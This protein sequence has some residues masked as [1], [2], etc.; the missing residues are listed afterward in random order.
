MNESH[1]AELIGC[2][3]TP[4]YS[5][6]VFHTL[7]MPNDILSTNETCHTYK[8]V[9]SHA[10]THN[11]FSIQ[12]AEG[13]R[14]RPARDLAAMTHG[15]V[16]PRFCLLCHRL[17]SK[18]SSLRPQTAHE[19]EKQNRNHNTHVGVLLPAVRLSSVERF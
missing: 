17:L 5:T 14:A 3:G 7:T 13:I 12:I 2:R 18:D 16:S 4:L 15:R 6:H 11:S 10:R 19:V 9:T 8:S 1:D